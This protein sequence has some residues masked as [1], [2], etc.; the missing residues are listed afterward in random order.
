MPFYK[1]LLIGL[2]A[3]AVVAAVIVGTVFYFTSGISDAATDFFATTASS[4]APAA[5]RKAAGGFR[6]AVSEQEFEAIADRLGLA[7]FKSASWP[8]REMQNGRGKVVG[9][10][11]LEGDV[12][13][14]ATVNLV[15]NEAGQWQVFNFELTPPGANPGQQAAQPQ[16]P[17]PPKQAEQTPAPPMKPQAP[18]AAEQKIESTAQAGDGISAKIGDKEWSSSGTGMIAVALGN[19]LLVQTTPSVESG[20]IDLTTLKLQFD[21][22]SLQE[23]TL[24]RDCNANGP[25]IEL[26]RDGHEFLIDRASKQPAVLK[27]TKADGNTVEGTFSADMESL[28]GKAAIR[29]GHFR[30]TL[31]SAG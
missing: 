8:T 25:C 20:D 27:I 18:K 17:E 31:K 13:L 24:A 19:V 30:V 3:V 29:D 26:S 10:V 6:Q 15:R 4:G 28:D 22:T 5:Y 16:A 9:T 14:P 12:T 7:G 11:T 23:Q 21:A 2:A 1:K